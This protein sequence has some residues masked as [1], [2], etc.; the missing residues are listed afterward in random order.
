M[1]LPLTVPLIVLLGRR[2]RARAQPHSVEPL[3][4]VG[5]A[6]VLVTVSLG[7]LALTTTGTIRL[8]CV[9]GSSLAL[10]G[11]VRYERHSVAPVIPR[12]LW[13]SRAFWASAGAIVV[14]GGATAL[15]FMVP[16]YLLHLWGHG[17]SWQ[18]GLLN[19]SA[20]L[21]LV[22]VSRPASR[23]L[24]RYPATRLMLGGLGLMAI[25]FA[26]IA[27]T[28]TAHSVVLLVLCL[29]SYGIGAAAFFPANLTKLLELTG[30]ENYGRMGA[31]QRMAI[32]L[33]TAVD[34]AVVG[35]LLVHGTAVERVASLSGARTSWAFGAMTLLLAMGGIRLSYASRLGQVP[36]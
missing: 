30:P 4:L 21:M 35:V 8:L 22:L 18:I 29:G 12:A 27:M 31:I 2:A 36:E 7:L 26:V 17:A 23:L 9:I 16:P 19:V 28:I 24:T 3:G 5:N 10:A 6:G 20:P 34:A 32:N 1:N 33:G 14:V 13:A 15:G 11:T 25:A